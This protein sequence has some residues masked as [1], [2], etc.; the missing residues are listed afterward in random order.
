M[1][2]DLNVGYLAGVLEEAFQATQAAFNTANQAFHP[3]KTTLFQFLH[4]G[5]IIL[6]NNA[7][8]F[9]EGNEKGA[10]R[11]SA[12]AKRQKSQTNDQIKNMNKMGRWN[13]CDSE[14]SVQK[15]LL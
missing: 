10:K 1:Q 6:D 8:E 14:A 7:N 4:L 13:R 2:S 9:Y 11:R 5:D 12:C 3:S 15:R